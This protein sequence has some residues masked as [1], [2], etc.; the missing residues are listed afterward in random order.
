MAAALVS[1]EWLGFC[2]FL[3]APDLHTKVLGSCHQSDS[4]I[5]AINILVQLH[6]FHQ[7]LEHIVYFK[8]RNRLK[9]F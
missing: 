9:D 7:N 2:S 8:H 1:A 6:C 5:I 3:V 4:H